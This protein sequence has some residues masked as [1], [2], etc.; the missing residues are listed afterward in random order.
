VPFYLENSKCMIFLAICADVN[1][2][3]LVILF[4]L[5]CLIILDGLYSVWS[6][7]CKPF[8]CISV[9]NCAIKYKIKTI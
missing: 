7:S 1:F 4:L 9:F 6:V 5:F 2:A 3:L 8:Y